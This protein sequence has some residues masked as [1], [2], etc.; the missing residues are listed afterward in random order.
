MAKLLSYPSLVE[1]P[2]IEVIIGD[3]VFGTYSRSRTDGKVTYPNFLESLNVIK[4]NGQVNQYTIKMVYQITTG[5][6][7]NFIDKVLSS[8][9]YSTI[10]IT[11]GDWKY[12]TLIYKKEEALITK[13]TSN[14]DFASSKISYTISCTSNALALIG[15]AY[16]FEYHAHEK[17]SKVILDI[18]REDKYGLLNIFTGMNK[19]S[20]LRDAP[21]AAEFS[22][23]NLIATDDKAV[24]IKAQ[25]KI[26][27]LAYLNYLVSCMIPNDS[28]DASTSTGVYK[29][30]IHD[31]T[32]TDKVYAGPTSIRNS[33]PY[34][35][36]TKIPV[37]MN[38][39][40]ISDC[41]EVDIGYPNT[42]DMVISFNIRDDNSWALLFN[43]SDKLQ[44]DYTY[45][46]DNEGNVISKYSPNI[47][48]SGL[49][50]ETTENI[51]TWWTEMTSF[52]ISAELV[53]KGLARAS[54]LMSYVKINAYF[55]G[56]KHDSSGLYIITR[57]EDSISA[58]GYRT[59][60][61]LTRVQGD[62]TYLEKTTDKTNET[63]SSD[64]N[65]QS[66]TNKLP[67]RK[68]LYV[69][70]GSMF[71]DNTSFIT[72][73]G[74]G[75]LIDHHVYGYLTKDVPVTSYRNEGDLNKDWAAISIIPADEK[76]VGP[77]ADPTGR[78]K[79]E[80]TYYVMWYYDVIERVVEE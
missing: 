64:N 20:D 29:L 19:R 3:H 50:N 49:F 62:I 60:L 14:V 2:F 30:T 5:D 12:P 36:V 24:E 13:V 1:S 42:N 61:S 34:F 25:H 11:Y 78:T 48:T 38:A 57:Q 35:T 22:I 45:T 76:L 21:E 71:Y 70:A 7:P 27:P 18:L 44:Q 65:K 10:K 31:D 75:G 39:L 28:Q 37:K 74:G 69:K 9:G 73:D 72:S 68:K 26:D 17:P 16:D 66:T 59:T 15:S 43:Y 4:V 33:G 51:K 8:V 56:Q 79:K 46:I 67:A 63:S 77:T 54:M 47:T 41:Y 6:D 58:S 80:G 32:F 40:A 52:P 55:Y 53:I 23:Y